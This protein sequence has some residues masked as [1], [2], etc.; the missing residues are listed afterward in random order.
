[1]Q[2]I[3]KKWEKDIPGEELHGLIV[4][5]NGEVCSYYGRYAHS[6]GHSVCTAEE[7]CHGRMNN[8]VKKTLG[9]RVLNEAL[10]LLN[11]KAP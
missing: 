4:Y 8:I 2:N 7:F 5:E 9:E 11:G 1:M 3:I 10:E 6:S